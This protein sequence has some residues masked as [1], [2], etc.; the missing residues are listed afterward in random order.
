MMYIIF[1][2]AIKKTGRKCCNVALF[3]S[4]EVL[5]NSCHESTTC[6][7]YCGVLAITGSNFWAWQAAAFDAQ[8]DFCIRVLNDNYHVSLLY[9]TTIWIACPNNS[10][11]FNADSREVH[12]MH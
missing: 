6:I 9:N 12:G 11:Q 2:P 5:L 7:D 3:S 10:V 8:F 4:H 1:L